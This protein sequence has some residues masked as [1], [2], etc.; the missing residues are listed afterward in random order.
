MTDRKVKFEILA[1]FQRQSSKYTGGETLMLNKYTAQWDADALIQSFGQQM[2]RQLIDRYF[3][4]ADHPSWKGFARDAQKI[5]ESMV[6][7]W[8]DEQSRSV[9]KKR[10]KEWMND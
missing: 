5:Y 10:V 1:Y 2:T 7:E 8:E 6:I 4:Y 3:L 9:M